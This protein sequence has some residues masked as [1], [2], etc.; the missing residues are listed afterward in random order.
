MATKTI[1]IGQHSSLDLK[2]IAEDGLWEL[3]YKAGG[4]LQV[5]ELKVLNH[6]GFI[7]R[8]E[9]TGID[10]EHEDGAVDYMKIYYFAKIA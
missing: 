6:A 10:Y 4:E 9:Q 1:K 2:Y 8:S 3:V 7:Y 5:S